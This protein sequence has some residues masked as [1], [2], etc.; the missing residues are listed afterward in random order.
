MGLILGSSAQ[1]FGGI[2]FVQNSSADYD[3]GIITSFPEGFGDG[4]FTL[5]IVVTPYQVTTIGPTATGSD[6]FTNW[7]NENETIYSSADWWFFGNFLLDGHNNDFDYEGTFDLQ[8]FNSGRIRWLFG[9]GSAANA[10]VGDMHGIQNPSG[11]SILDGS[12]HV[13][14]C[15]RR[16]SD[17]PANS[18]DLELYVDGTL[19]DTENSTNRTNMASTYWDSW[20]SFPVGQDNW[21]FAA[22]KNA[23]LDPGD[24]ADYK[25]LIEEVT[26]YNGALSTGDISADQG[27]VDTGH[28]DYADHFGFREGTGN[29]SSEN[30]IT[31]TLNNA[32]PGGFWP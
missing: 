5:K 18:A 14:H 29:P 21:M 25:G 17:S 3:Y 31:M 20:T 9:D 28:A 10:R 2:Q 11:I 6:R 19:Q 24:W 4:E 16:W 13:I 23:A 7:A 15:V 22:E 30:G 26:F 32:Q 1:S 12:R 8:V 27:V